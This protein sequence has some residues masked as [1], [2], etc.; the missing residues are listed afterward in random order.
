MQAKRIRNT[1][2][3]NPI[4]MS[5]YLAKTKHPE[6]GKWERAEWLDYHFAPHHYGV[7]FPDGKVF[8]PEKVKC[9]QEDLS[10]PYDKL[11]TKALDEFDGCG[12]FRRQVVLRE[13]MEKAYNLGKNEGKS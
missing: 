10:T 4:F 5:N 11:V 1:L 7:R 9:E 12:D 3:L 2:T 6:T 13:Y 8:D